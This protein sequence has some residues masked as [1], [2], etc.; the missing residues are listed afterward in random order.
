MAGRELIVANGC[1]NDLGEANGLLSVTDARE[2]DRDRYGMCSL[3]DG[4]RSSCSPGVCRGVLGLS[5]T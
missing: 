1:R 4:R 5:G 2:F 3:V